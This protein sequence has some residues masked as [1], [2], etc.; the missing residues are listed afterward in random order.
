MLEVS[1]LCRAM[2]SPPDLDRGRALL[3][4]ARHCCRIDVQ[5]KMSLCVRRVIA[6]PRK[7]HAVLS[8]RVYS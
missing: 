1:R 5:G 7:G 6:R 2:S 4:L 3:F 8:E